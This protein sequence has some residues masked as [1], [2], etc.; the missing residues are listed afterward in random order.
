MCKACC[1][2]VRRAWQMTCFMIINKDRAWRLG[3]LDMDVGAWPLGPGCAR[4]YP[5]SLTVYPAKTL[6]YT[7]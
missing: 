1:K 6:G 7:S 4:L 3:S 2:N 5:K